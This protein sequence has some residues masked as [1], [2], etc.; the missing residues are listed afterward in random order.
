MR[1]TMP[2]TTSDARRADRNFG[3]VTLGARTTVFFQ[4]ATDAIALERGEIVDEQF[5]VE[6]IHL[7]LQTHGG[8][9]GEFALEGDAVTVLGAHGHALCALDLVENAGH[10]PTLEQPEK[11]NAALRAWLKET[12][13]G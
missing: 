7:V 9:L 6:M 12:D 10:L 5:A 8:E 4:F 2:A 11:T 3:V 1:T 13:N